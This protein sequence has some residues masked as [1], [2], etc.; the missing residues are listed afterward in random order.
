MEKEEKIFTQDEITEKSNALEK[1]R[2]AKAKTNKSY[3]LDLIDEAK[4]APKKEQED[5]LKYA[6]TMIAAAKKEKTGGEFN[7]EELFDEY[8]KKKDFDNFKEYINDIYKDEKLFDVD[9]YINDVIKRIEEFPSSSDFVA[10][11]VRNLADKSLKKENGELK[12]SVFITIFHQ[13]VNHGI[14]AKK[15]KEIIEENE[16][17]QYN[18]DFWT[19]QY[20]DLMKGKQSDFRNNYMPLAVAYDLSHGINLRTDQQQITKRE[21]YMFAF[22]F[23]MKY[24][25]D[26]EKENFDKKK[27]ADE[28]ELEYEKNRDIELQLFQNYYASTFFNGK[29]VDVNNTEREVKRQQLNT[30]DGVDLKNFGEVIYLYYLRKGRGKG[31]NDCRIGHANQMIGRCFKEF[32]RNGK[33]DTSNGIKTQIYSEGIN[34]NLEKEK[35][36]ESIVNEFGLEP[37]DSSVENIGIV[38]REPNQVTATDICVKFSNYFFEKRKMNDV[39]NEI[40]GFR[41]DE[42]VY[43]NKYKSKSGKYESYMEKIKMPFESDKVSREKLI[44]LYLVR[45]LDAIKDYNVDKSAISFNFANMETNFIGEKAS[46]NDLLKEARY[47]PFSTKNLFDAMINCILLLNC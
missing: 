37:F 40:Y 9:S 34:F 14:M 33:N 13:F 12:Y 25:T 23:D 26:N 11:T 1:Q 43:K 8:K 22:A 18:D 24:Y 5:S 15:V 35:F 17:E 2:V 30:S 46:L 32:K 36:E 21:L 19:N 20:R 7:D 41:F 31:K 6:A 42:E 38:W 4:N 16:N 27:K 45:F 28:K 3:L 44:G 47:Q 29:V 10:R 39:N